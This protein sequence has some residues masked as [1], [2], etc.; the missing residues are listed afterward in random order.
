[1]K[2][3]LI[4]FS[5]F[6]TFFLYSCAS[7]SDYSEFGKVNFDNNAD[8]SSFAFLVSDEYIASHA[9][10]PSDK[11]YPK[12]TEAEAKLLVKILKNNQNCLDK[13]GHP[14]FVIM[15][16]Q[17]KIYDTTFSHLIEQNYN[18]RPVV[19]AMYFGR[20]SQRK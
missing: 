2:K 9:K 1:M 3:P 14:S 6:A 19:P 4:I 18:A 11:N 8:R 15:S 10:S 13:N 7:N 20:C 17:E 5:Y 12:M 16:K